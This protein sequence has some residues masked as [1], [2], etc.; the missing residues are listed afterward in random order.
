MTYYIIVTGAIRISAPLQVAALVLCG[1][2]VLF[3]VA[4]SYQAD[5]KTLVSG[6]FYIL[7]GNPCGFYS[8]AV[9]Y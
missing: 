7:A 6:V 8:Y 2:A 4:G 3:S 5:V 1:L 9:S